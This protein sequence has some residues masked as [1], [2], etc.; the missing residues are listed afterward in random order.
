M[1]KLL[2]ASLITAAC[3][4]STGTNGDPAPAD[5]TAVCASQPKGP[6][7]L[8]LTL[9]QWAEGARLFDG[10]GN[11]HRA[12]TT[13]SQAAQAYFDQGMRLLWAFNH[14]EAT[15]SFAKAAE[16]DPR[17]AM[18]YWG[19]SLTV[20]PNYNLPMMAQP[21]AAVAWQ[22]LQQAQQQAA[23]ATPVEQALIGALAQRYPNAQPLDPSNE[24]PVLAAYA[25][26]MKTVA[27]RFPDDRDVQTLTAEAMMN[28]NAWK[29]WSLDG[30]PAPG[31]EEIVALL[32]RVLAMDPHHPGANH[33][34]IHAVEAS[35]N[36]GR[37]IPSAERLPGMMPAAGHLEHMPAHI[38]QRVG[39]YESAAE[40]NRKGVAADLAYFAETKPLDYYVMYTAHNYQ[41]LAFSAAMEGRQAETMEA[42][43][44]SRALVPDD[45]LLMMPGTDWYTAELYAAMV[46]FGMWDEIL[47]EPVPNPKL[48]GLTGAYLYAKA[49]ALAAKG[50][51][52]DA[53]TELGK[54]EKLTAEAAHDDSAGL[55]RVKDVLAVAILAAQGPHRPCREQARPGDKAY[56]ARRGRAGRQAGL[57]GTGRLVLP[58]PAPAWARSCSDPARRRRRRRSIATTSAVI[59]ITAGRCSA[60]PGRWKRRAS[61]AE[62]ANRAA[63]IRSRLGRTRM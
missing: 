37:A 12:V 45:M 10:L 9:A 55:N 11:F 47:A 46:R 3:L 14:D 58:E 23:A 56:C 38:M 15:R 30:V 60:S 53:K 29:L 57:L 4:A 39:R 26:A 6:G 32:E 49:T 52:D 18:C 22:A 8:P 34:Y 41:F 59:R 50:K 40:A 43:R 31:T 19:V 2:G 27:P 33:Y 44:Q 62:G 1:R 7:G 13:D 21:R 28:I 24:G 42:V 17:C 36:P 61:A 5:K 48:T 63:A 16:L 20:G 35:L 51:A 54:L 25:Q